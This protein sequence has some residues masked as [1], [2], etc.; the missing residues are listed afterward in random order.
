MDLNPTNVAIRPS[1]GDIRLKDWENICVEGESCTVNGMRGYMAPE[2][3][4]SG[5]Q[6]TPNI[7]TDQFPW[8]FVLFPSVL[9]MDHPME[10]KY[11]KS[12]R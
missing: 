12:F 3:V 9:I 1:D 8:Q 4:R 11:G 2:I 7:Q 6:V 10:G 5:F